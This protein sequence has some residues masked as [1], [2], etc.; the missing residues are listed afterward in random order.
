MKMVNV[1]NYCIFSIMLLGMMNVGA[2][3][4]K[5]D[6]AL[7]GGLVQVTGGYKLE[8][9]IRDQYLD[10]YINDDK[11]KARSTDNITV[12]ASVVD[13]KGKQAI[14]FESVTGNQLVAHGDFSGDE[15][16]VVVLE[17]MSPDSGMDTVV[18][19]KEASATGEPQHHWAGYEDCT[20]GHDSCW[21]S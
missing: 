19:I 7:H 17:M 4:T 13:E 18:F 10:L 3:E 1:L 16:Y 14:H 20:G 21:E 2:D 11:G 5:A 9:V 6:V 12:N 8:L 15:V